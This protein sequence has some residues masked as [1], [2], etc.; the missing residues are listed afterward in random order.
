MPCTPD[1]IRARLLG[2]VASIPTPF[3][4]RGDIHWDGVANII[5]TAIAGGSGVMLLTIGDSQYFFMTEAEIADITRFVIERV[6]GRALTV[7]ATGPWATRQALPFAEYCRDL[8]ADVVMSLAPAMMTGGAGLVAHYRQ[9]AAVMPV[10]VVGAPEMS[11]ADALVDEPHICCF[12]E[13]G[14]EA[15]AISLLQRHGRRWQVMTGGGLYRHLFQWPFGARAFMDWTTSVAPHLGR[16]YW[17]A[18]QAGHLAEAE[19]ITREVEAPLFALCG[20]GVDWQALW[21]AML[22]GNGIAPRHLRAPMVTLDDATVE[23]I[24]PV[25]RAAGVCR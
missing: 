9:L 11:V 13:D 2:P 10:M 8:G 19:R 4:A 1:E 24:R 16:A 12:K 7:A 25:L 15:Y 17:D 18:L 22:E 21:R 14:S 20:L 3:D 6:A 5:E 23:R